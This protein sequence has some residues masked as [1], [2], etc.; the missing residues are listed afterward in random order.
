MNAHDEIRDALAAYALGALDS[1]EVPAVEAHL[2]TCETCRAALA[3]QRRVVAGIGLASEPIA[4]PAALKARVLAQATAQPQRQPD[5]QAPAGVPVWRG[6]AALA[7]A[8]AL[9]LAAA[10][11]V[12]AL[13]MRARLA[14]LDDTVAVLTAP[15]MLR[16]ELKGQTGAANATGRA[17][18]STSR[19]LVFSAEN[20]PALD[21]ARVYQVWTIH[22][23]KPVSAGLLQLDRSGGAAHRS[24]PPAGATPPEAV[25]VSI[26]PRG[27][28]T[29]PTGAIVLMGKPN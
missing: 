11:S 26:E 27:G 19:G 14:T 29:A 21:P 24:P 13:S 10:A 12:W 28:V 9:V 6:P 8:A 18:W 25:A 3:D 5:R 16:V 1:A 20:L 22:N 2:A 4:P 23:G 17:F 7:V 15:D